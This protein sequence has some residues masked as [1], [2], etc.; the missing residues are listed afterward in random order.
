[1]ANARRVQESLRV[2]EEFAKLS[3]SA[4][5]IKPLK[6]EQARFLIYELEQK[7]LF[8]ILRREIAGRL[9][10]LYLIIDTKALAGRNEI[11]VATQA[12][13]GGANVIQLRDKQHTKTELLEMSRKLRQVSAEKEVLF[14]INDYLDIAEACGAD[15]VH[16]G[17]GDLS[18]TEARP[19]I[20]P[21]K[22]IGF[23]THTLQEAVMAESEGADYIAVGSIYPTTSKEGYSLAGIETLQ[24]IR[25]KTTLPL[26]AIGGIN[27]RNAEYVMEAGADGIAVISAVLGAEDVER[28]ARELTTK[29]ERAGSENE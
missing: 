8:K 18:I 21:D 1:T 6:L 24:Q 4:L 16:L 5:T 12:I 28:A 3:D 29:I 22:I 20:S 17:Q 15:G 13:Q 23:S 14:I 2:L 25:E 19:L 9:S 26:I 7:I 27:N 10:G 11:E